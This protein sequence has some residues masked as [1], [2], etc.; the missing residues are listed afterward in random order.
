MSGSRED[1][2]DVDGLGVVE[3]T[4]WKRSRVGVSSFSR[5]L[6]NREIDRVV[7]AI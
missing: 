5:W 6:S 1:S 3:M 7:G 4:C 2:G